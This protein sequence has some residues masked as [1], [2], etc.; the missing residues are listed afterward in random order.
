MNI[1]III[2]VSNYSDTKNNLPGC[3]NDAEAIYRILQKTEKFN[4]ILFLNE[5]E[6]SA[7]TKELLIKF[8]SE[9]KGK[10]I[11]EFFFYYS[12]HGEFANEQFYYL[13]SDFDSKKR[14]QTSLQNSEMDD[15]IRTLAPELIIKVIDACQSGASYIKESNV[16]SKYFDESKKAFKK[17]YFFNSSLNTQ[18]SYQDQKISHFTFSFINAILQHN[19]DEIRYKDIIDVISDDFSSNPE[20]T[21]FFITQADFTEIFCSIPKGL[22]DYLREFK[23]PIKDNPLKEDKKISIV[24]LVKQTAKDYTD[25]DGALKTLEY[26]REQFSN[27]KLDGEINALFTSEVEFLESYQDVDKIKV[28]TDW[29]IKNPNDFF[30]TPIY[31]EVYDDFGEEFVVSNKF[32][33]KV[34]VPY[35]AISINLLNNFPNISSYNCKIVFLLSRKSIRFFYYITNYIEESWDNKTINLSD[36][37]W[38]TRESN[39][40]DI[41]SVTTGLKL[42]NKTFQDRIEKDIKDK[43]DISEPK[44][45]PKEELNK[46][47]PE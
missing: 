17:C 22:R 41:A 9:H 30:A 5:C 32:E 33:L 2:G 18:S 4:P 44:D 47:T 46:T 15:L 11:D 25:K 38:V 43:F 27:Y 23:S 26:I 37:K 14:N 21:P 19:S 24:D 40:A 3:R 35:K 13:L 12:G 8:I 16:L 34:D 29:I 6:P 36:I 20:Q 10:H 39:I 31:E 45:K 28:V 42:M 7:K 1:A